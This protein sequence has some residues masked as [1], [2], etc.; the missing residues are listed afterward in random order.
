MMRLFFHTLP[1]F[2]ILFFPSFLFAQKTFKSGPLFGLSATQVDG[3]GYGGFNKAGLIAGGF[4]LT[5]LK[6]KLDIQFEIYYINKGSRRNPRPDKG[7]HDAFLLKINYI[8]V[9]VTFLYHYKKFSAELGA[10]IGYKIYDYMADENG[11]LPQQNI[12]FESTDIGGSLGIYYHFSEH[13][14][15]SWRSSNSFLPIREYPSI[16][17]HFD[18]YNR[19]F[20][21]GWYNIV[22]T[23]CF[24]YT[25]GI[26]NPS[27]NE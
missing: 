27:E 17:T 4:V 8:E 5:E 23:L 21:R 10:Y 24:R 25:F 13:W 12:L 18:I 7:D 9:P 11:E 22:S 2:F 15:L 16:D 19:I 1:L 20:N 14:A 6:P 3:D 26:K